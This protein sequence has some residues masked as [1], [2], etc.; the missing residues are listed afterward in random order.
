MSPMQGGVD[1]DVLGSATQQCV[2]LLAGD[3]AAVFFREDRIE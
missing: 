2:D 1:P 3:E